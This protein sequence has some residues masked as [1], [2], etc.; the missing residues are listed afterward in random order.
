[1]IA[2]ATQQCVVVNKMMAA[3]RFR[4][5]FAEDLDKVLKD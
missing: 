3:S 2:Y 4:G 1:M 5:F